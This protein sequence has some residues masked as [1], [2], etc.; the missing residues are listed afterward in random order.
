MKRNW[1]IKWRLRNLQEKVISLHEMSLKL[2]S[3]LK[4]KTEDINRKKRT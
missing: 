1:K 3:G 2:R 4:L